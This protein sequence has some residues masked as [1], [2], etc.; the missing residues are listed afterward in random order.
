MQIELQDNH[1]ML[2][3]HALKVVNGGVPSPPHRFWQ[4]IMHTHHQHILIMGTIENADHASAWNDPMD[5]PEEIMRLF[6]GRRSLKRT[7]LASQRIDLC[8]DLANRAIFAAR[9]HPL[10]DDE[11]AVMLR[12]RHQLL[13]LPQFSLSF[14]VSAAANARSVYLSTMSGS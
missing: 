10:E 11:Q 14:S 13:H 7:H 1:V 6:P 12:R 8:H 3:Q 4:Q 9:I 5:P 2:G